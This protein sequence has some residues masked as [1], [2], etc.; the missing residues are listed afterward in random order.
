ME[1][2]IQLLHSGMKRTAMIM[3]GR[4]VVRYVSTT[5]LF[6]FFSFSI[7][8]A[9][10]YSGGSGTENDPYLIS[11]KADME[12][13]ANNYNSEGKYYLLTNNIT[14]A[15]TTV[16]GYFQG[17]FDGGGNCINVNI[18]NNGGAAGV[19][20]TLY[21]AT[22]KNLKVNGNISTSSNIESYSAG[23]CGIAYNA[24]ITNCSNTGRV[25]STSSYSFPYSGGICGY[26]KNNTIIT[27]CS[28]TGV[29][30]TSTS[31][32]NLNSYSGGICGYTEYTSIT[33][34][35]NAGNI[36]SY[37]SNS[38]VNSA[39]AGGI[40]GQVGY[41]STITNC[42]NKGDISSVTFYGSS[43]LD[44][45][46]YHN[47]SYSG[48]ICGAVGSDV[49][50]SNCMVANT[51]I[52]SYA[53]I[54]IKIGLGPTNTY[55]G[56]IYIGRIVGDGGS[57]ENCYA[58]ASIL[59]NNYPLSS[60]DANSKDGKDMNE[61]DLGDI[62]I[63]TDFSTCSQSVTT[64]ML[65]TTN[66]I[67]WQRSIDNEQSWTDIDCKLPFYTETNLAAGAYIY[68]ALNGNATYSSYV[69]GTYHNA[70]PSKINALPLAST[71]KRVD[72]S[73]TFNL[74]LTDDNYS[75]QWYKNDEAIS[76]ATS[77]SYSIP[78]LK[79]SD[80]GVYHCRI[81]N[82]CNEEASS[83]TMLIMDKATQVI[84]LPATTLTKAYGDADFNLPEFTDKNQTIAYSSSNTGVA[85][86]TGNQVHIVGVGTT[87]I[88]AAQTGNSEYLAASP[89]TLS[90]SVN[91]AALTVT[92]DNATR[93]QGQT[94]PVFTFSY[95]GFKNNE[96][97][98]VLDE[99]PVAS[100]AADENSIPGTYEIVLSGGF[101]NN[102]NYTLVNGTLEVTAPNGLEKIGTNKI[103]VY[104]NPVKNDI[105]IQS[106]LAIK[107][108]EIFNISGRIVE[109]LRATSLRENDVQTINA[110]NLPQGIY[111][112]TVYTDREMMVYKIVKE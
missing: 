72:E 18:S 80:A 98:S 14:E 85:T 78:I 95:S 96:N 19:F 23:I 104:P 70:V 42:S 11:S 47:H 33:N 112:V 48:G 37:S 73:I 35:S 75:Y 8:T 88:T 100:C 77:N 20:S 87:T 67:K 34:C 99:L 45:A 41:S 68:R 10:T 55:D 84:T 6:L 57:I 60:Q 36:S 51:T 21:G 93:P 106:E 58:F 12:E 40:C 15:V 97:Y 74:E 31:T 24:I 2:Q 69:K 49:K 26:A 101:D 43:Y 53:N 105:F 64:I 13:L 4:D 62:F 86:V 38:S 63:N 82:G 30:S 111:F 16:I 89:A 108:I 66:T 94:N 107:K 91:K 81:W 76:G 56:D 90:L 22:V 54:Y 50:V 27:N 46:R 1:K 9:Q 109:T 5:I 83:N 79:M 110:S 44:A 25:S 39:Y 32:P 65:N 3:H 17:V 92:A 59:I 71:S 52:E 7:V 61:N 29:I 28:N 103:S 102:Y